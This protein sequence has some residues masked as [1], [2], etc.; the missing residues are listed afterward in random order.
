MLWL[1]VGDYNVILSLDEKKGCLPR[2]PRPMEEFRQALLH[3]GLSDLGFIGN[4]FT[5]RNGRLRRAFVQ[6]RLGRACANTKWREIYPFSRVHHLHAAYSNHE[7]IL[8]TTQEDT[9][10]I[11]RRR[12]PKRFEER[13]ALDPACEGV[14]REA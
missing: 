8:I 14:I 3:C 11:R 1:C 10:V 6:E 2:P 7:P 13:W 9:Q 4:I 12:K 5:W